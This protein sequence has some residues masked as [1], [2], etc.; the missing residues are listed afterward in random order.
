ML[1][2]RE[3]RQKESFAFVLSDCGGEIQALYSCLVE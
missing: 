1:F 2:K 3:H